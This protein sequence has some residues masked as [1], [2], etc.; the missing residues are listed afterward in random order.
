MI[1]TIQ[2]VEFQASTNLVLRS[3][4]TVTLTA[5]LSDLELERITAEHGPLVFGTDEGGSITPDAHNPRMARWTPQKMTTAAYRATVAV[6]GKHEKPHVIGE[7]W[8][9]AVAMPSEK[10]WQLG[11]NDGEKGVE[12]GELIY[13]EVVGPLVES[14]KLHWQFDTGNKGTIHS[15]NV[16]GKT[17]TA[18]WDTSGMPATPTP[19][20]PFWWTSGDPP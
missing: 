2:T 14:A 19:C 8:I 10:E 12:E 7:T 6:A 16:T 9:Y 5:N 1:K 11:V 13:L 20:A 4:D 18:S 15:D 3:K 17:V